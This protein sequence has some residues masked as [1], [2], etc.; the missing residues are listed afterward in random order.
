MLDLRTWIAKRISWRRWGEK[1]VIND[2]AYLPE[3]IVQRL[4]TERQ[5]LVQKLL[6]ERARRKAA[7]AR[8]SGVRAC[9]PTAVD[10]CGFCGG[11]VPAGSECLSSESAGRCAWYQERAAALLPH[12]IRELEGHAVDMESHGWK[13]AAETLRALIAAHG[14][15]VGHGETFSQQTPMESN[16]R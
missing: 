8:T 2:Q 3:R 11:D 1:V 12:R 10:H 6:K 9:A 4:F 15:G 7:E 14:V 16:P 13:D 5:Q